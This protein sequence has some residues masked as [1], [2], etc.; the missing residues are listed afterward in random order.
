MINI[1]TWQCPPTLIEKALQEW[2]IELSRV[3]LNTKTGDTFYDEWELKD[4]YK[5]SA[6]AELLST[7][8][9]KIGEAR[10][11]SLL[12]GQSYRAHADVDNRWH[13][14]LT[15]NHSY[16]IDLTAQKLYQQQRDSHWQ[17]ML[18]D[19]IHTG[20]N[21]GNITRMQL[22]V[23]QPLQHSNFKKLI[24]VEISPAYSQIDYRYQFDSQI[25]PWLNQKNQ[26]GTMDD[27]RYSGELVSFSIANCVKRELDAIDR[28][29][30][31][32]KYV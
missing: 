26:E 24:P 30:F 18:A 8:P 19:R 11:I 3:T 2:P 16:L 10:V 29:R 1:T 21:F 28:T 12:P 20:S 17:Y 31:T 15:G 4:E 27:F 32:I 13:L 5:E 9:C 7:L 22:V 14:N 23:R 25:S 6:W